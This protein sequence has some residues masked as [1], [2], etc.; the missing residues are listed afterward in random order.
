MQGLPRNLGQVQFDV[1]ARAARDCPENDRWF[2][3]REFIPGFCYDCGGA[4]V[5]EVAASSTSYIERP[6]PTCCPLSARLHAPI[7]A[8][9]SK[10]ETFDDS[11]MA[12]LRRAVAH[13]DVTLSHAECRALLREVVV[14]LDAKAA[15]GAQTT[16]IRTDPGKGF[17]APGRKSLLALAREAESEGGEI[18]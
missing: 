10:T 4:G 5:I 7:E 16:E 14:F 1:D 8:D 6:C 9:Q 15:A 3:M 11:P 13:P 12:R 2:D 17:A 18:G